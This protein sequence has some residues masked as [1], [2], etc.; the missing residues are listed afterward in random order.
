MGSQSVAG[1]IDAAELEM[2]GTALQGR[3]TEKISIPDADYARDFWNGV[4]DEGL[5]GSR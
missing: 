2:R 4:D 1:D 3:P 5:G